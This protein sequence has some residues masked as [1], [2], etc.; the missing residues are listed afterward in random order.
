MKRVTILTF[1]RSDYASVKPVALAALQDP[2]LDLTLVAGGSHCVERFGNTIDEVKADGFQQLE[3]VDFMNQDDSSDADLT[4]AFARA[5]QQLGECFLKDPPDRIFI[6]GD[7][8]E[9]LAAA[10]AAFMARIPIVHHS[11]GDLT[12]GSAD[13]QTRY[14]LFKT[15]AIRGNPFFHVHFFKRFFI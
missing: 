9:M 1:S 3:I 2:D 15:I 10:N 7:R 5:V 8:W 12:Q 6:L 14:A 4:R 11:G 13:N